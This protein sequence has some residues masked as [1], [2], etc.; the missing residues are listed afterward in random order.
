MTPSII[1]ATASVASSLFSASINPVRAETTP[2]IMLEDWL[3]PWQK[4]SNKIVL[5]TPLG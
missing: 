2:M 3:T 4:A 1:E 5:I